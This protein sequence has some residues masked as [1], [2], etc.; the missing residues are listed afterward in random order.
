MDAGARIRGCRSCRHVGPC[1]RLPLLLVLQELRDNT[2][3]DIHKDG[4]SIVPIIPTRAGSM[5]EPGVRKSLDKPGL[6]LSP[7]YRREDSGSRR[8]QCRESDLRSSGPNSE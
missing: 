2:V 4:A 3:L 7:E 6:L 5:P 1:H 8:E